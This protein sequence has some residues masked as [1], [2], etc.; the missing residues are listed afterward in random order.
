M[1][2]FAAEFRI[3]PNTVQRALKILESEKIIDSV[4]ASGKYV[5]DNEKIIKKAK[6]KYVK[7]LKDAYKTKM[8]E[9]G[10]EI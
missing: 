8:R 1:R 6:E 4:R 9:I 7:E 3:N 2:D 10:E 5:T